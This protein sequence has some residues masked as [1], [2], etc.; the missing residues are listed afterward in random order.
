MKAVICALGVLFT[1]AVGALVVALGAPIAPRPAP[2]SA[3]DLSSLA[4]QPHPG[5][6]LPLATTLFDERGAGV[7]LSDYFT[8]SPV[9]VVLDYL[10]CRSLCGVTMRNLLETLARLPFRPGR[11]YQLVSIS[12]DPRD[13]PA[14]AVDAQSKYADLLG[15]G[16]GEG[17]IH[18]LTGSAPAVRAIADTVGF[19]YRYDALLDAY[20]HP[21]GFVIA[22]P[23]GVVSRYLEGAAASPAELVDALAAAEE[24]KSQG[25]LTRLLLLCHVQSAPIGRL[26]VPVLAAFTAADLVAGVTLVAVFIAIRRRRHA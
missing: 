3:D 19:P 10:R 18:F 17:A 24:D 5:A 8:R 7:V 13:T 16:H 26:T 2:E 23:N 21:A 22:T 11:D 1:L 14:D 4:F 20:I 9:I 6:Q 15:P 25:P 12:I